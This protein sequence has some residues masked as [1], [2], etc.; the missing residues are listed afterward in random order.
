VI[1]KNRINF[2]GSYTLIDPIDGD[3]EEKRRKHPIDPYD[4]DFEW[5]FNEVRRMFESSKFRAWL[6]EAMRKCLEAEEQDLQGLNIDIE[7]VGKPIFR[8]SSDLL[9][10]LSD[11]TVNYD[12]P[13]L[14]PDIIEGE[15]DV[16]ITVHLPEAYSEFIDLRV[17]Q[18]I[19]ELTFETQ[20]TT[21]FR[22]ISLPCPVKANTIRKKYN[23][24]VLDIAIKKKRKLRW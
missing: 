4:D 2:G 8:H 16:F 12:E 21:C 19:L 9:D 23:N 3:H 22:H 13:D 18:N 6:K 11:E 17:T 1:V 24:G 14:E 15:K 5:L 7:P 20:E 10:E